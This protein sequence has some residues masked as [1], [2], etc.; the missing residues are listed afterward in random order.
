[1][2]WLLPDI[3]TPC[4]KQSRK[5]SLLTYPAILKPIE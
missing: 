1:V 3:A 5:P 4:N 2:F